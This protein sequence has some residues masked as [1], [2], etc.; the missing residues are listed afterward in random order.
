MYTVM[1]TGG[2]GSGKSELVRQLVAHG[3]ASLD[4]DAIGHAV[5][6]EDAD[7]RRELAERFGAD[8]LDDAG[9]VDRGVL[10]RRAFASPE[11]TGALDAVMLERIVA[12][13]ADYLVDVHCA[14]VTDAPVQV[15]EVALLDR[16]PDFARLADERIAVVAP[17]DLRLARAIERG[18]D[19]QDA[20]ARIAAQAADAELERLAD[21][22]CDNSGTKAEL[23][24]WARRWWD[25]HVAAG[26]WSA[27][28]SPAPS[29]DKNAPAAAAGDKAHG[30]NA[31]RDRPAASGD[32]K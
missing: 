24:A 13:A 19:A 27:P 8:I 16:V 9:E 11:A 18:M 1:V 4:L 23:A 2:L 28:A 7:A 32:R 20:L 5:L 25:G 10:A 22:V 3:A 15:V 29:A 31:N 6:A 21:T 30:A 12:R 26:D 14:P 17:S